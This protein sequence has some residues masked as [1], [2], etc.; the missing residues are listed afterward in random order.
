MNVQQVTPAFPHILNAAS[1]SLFFVKAG[2]KRSPKGCLDKKSKK[3][4]QLKD[5]QK[6]SRIKY[7]F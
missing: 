3:A 5:V 4:V 1:P 7:N 2:A 6:A